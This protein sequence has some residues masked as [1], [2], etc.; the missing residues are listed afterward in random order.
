MEQIRSQLHAISKKLERLEINQGLHEMKLIEAWAAI[1][2]ATVINQHAHNEIA[3]KINDLQNNIN[4]LQAKLADV[5]LTEEQA[6]TVNSVVESARALDDIVNEPVSAGPVA[7]TPALE[8][9]VTDTP[10]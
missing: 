10:V 1:A 5:E 9:T 7:E 2:A 3:K 4:D 8:S 6:A